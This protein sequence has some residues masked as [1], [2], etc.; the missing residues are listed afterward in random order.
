MQAVA[1]AFDLKQQ[2]CVLRPASQVISCCGCLPCAP[3]F[4][5]FCCAAAVCGCVCV[6]H[7]QE[8]EEA[9]DRISALCKTLFNVSDTQT[10]TVCSQLHT[11]AD[12]IVGRQLS[13]QGAS[14]SRGTQNRR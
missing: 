5:L 13:C 3:I 2:L 6:G 12:C 9:Y 7:M 1:P 10:L 14:R 4:V 8:P 11:F